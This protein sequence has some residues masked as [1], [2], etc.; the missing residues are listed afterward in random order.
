MPPP[1]LRVPIGHLGAL[2]ARF[3]PPPIDWRRVRRQPSLSG[4]IRV[5]TQASAM[6]PTASS[7]RNGSLAASLPRMPETWQDG[8]ARLPT[9][10]F[11]ETRSF[12]LDMNVSSRLEQEHGREFYLS[13]LS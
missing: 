3:H 12:S 9:T 11:R 13:W 8:G 1:A 7:L 2:R 6:P 5:F 10:S 4:R